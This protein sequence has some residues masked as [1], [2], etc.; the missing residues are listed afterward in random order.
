M[1]A[2]RL[3]LDEDVHKKVASSLRVRGYDVASA[4][5]L[6]K[7]GI[8][9]KHQLEFAVSEGRAILAFNVRDYI[10]LHMEYIDTGRN[11]YGIIISKQLPIGETINRLLRLLSMKEADDT[12]DQ[13]LWL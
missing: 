7:W 13:L 10:K 8:E 2:V 6:G 1:R 3:Y 5:E 12:V 4:H 11:H 9:D